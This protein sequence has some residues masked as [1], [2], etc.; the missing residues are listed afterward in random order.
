MKAVDTD[1]DG[2]IRYSGIESHFKIF[3]H[4]NSTLENFVNLWSRQKMSSGSSSK[5]LIVTTTGI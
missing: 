1:G 4:A 5:A 3:D 2:H